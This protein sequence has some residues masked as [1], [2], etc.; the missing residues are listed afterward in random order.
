MASP[1]RRFLHLM[2]LLLLHGRLL[3]KGP[4][5]LAAGEGGGGSHIVDRKQTMISKKSGIAVAARSCVGVDSLSPI[6]AAALWPIYR[7][8]LV[9]IVAFVRE[10]I[11]RGQSFTKGKARFEQT[12]CGG[13]PRECVVFVHAAVT[14]RR[15]FHVVQGQRG[16]MIYV[17]M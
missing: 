6:C 2:M 5:K 15:R 8:R 4:K 7:D 16:V 3:L 13:A 1:R 9:V 14:G 17:Q 10:F 12:T 11:Y